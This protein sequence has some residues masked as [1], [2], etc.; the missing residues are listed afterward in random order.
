M[1]LLV[2]SECDFEDAHSIPGLE[3]AYERKLVAAREGH[4]E[5]YRWE[6]ET[7]PG[8]F[9]QAAPETDDLLFRYTESNMGRTKPWPQIEAELAHLNETA[10]ENVLYKLLICARHGQGY[11]NYIVDKY[12][13]EAWDDK[14]Y[15]MGT[16][17]EVE[18]GPDPMLTDL[19]IAQAQENNR[20]WTR[21]VR[22]HQAPIPSKFY[23]SPLQRSCWT[24]VYTWDGLRPADRKPVVVEKMRETL[25]RNLCDKRSLKTVIEL[26]FGKHGFETEPG[27]AE[28]DPLFTPEREA[29][30]DLAMRINSVCQDLFEEDWDCVN[31]VVDKSKA[32][33]NSVI[34]TTTHAGTIRLFIV[35]LG[36]RRFTLSTG[37]M[38]PIVVKA[39]R[40]GAERCAK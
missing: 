2:P 28:E 39:T 8:F 4:P 3:S 36:H 5:A 22:H 7:V 12:G 6:F 14:W 17:G 23:V 34:S 25:G 32:A 10:P 30:D 20:A 33:Q 16:D 15:C 40:T 11:H 1:S 35:V 37:G 13:L 9:Q 24:C 31:G 38:V 29:A 27:F 21:E 26:R 19:G 18:Y